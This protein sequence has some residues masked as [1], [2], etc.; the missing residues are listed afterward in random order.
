MARSEIDKAQA[1]EVSHKV[2]TSGKMTIRH[3]H[4][5]GSAL[6]HGYGRPRFKD[7]PIGR[8]GQ[9]TPA[10]HGPTQADPSADIP[11]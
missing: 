2:D 8:Q 1:N 6:M 10:D 7:T 11:I 4:T 5:P 3:R 9:M